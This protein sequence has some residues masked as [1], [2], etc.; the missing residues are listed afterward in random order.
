M[1]VDEYFIPGITIFN[2]SDDQCKWLNGTVGRQN[3][4]FHGPGAIHPFSLR[5]ESSEDA[6]AFKIRFSI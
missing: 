2:I 1:I 6:L 3:W 4:Q 5:F